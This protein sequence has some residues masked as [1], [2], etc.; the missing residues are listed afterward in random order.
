[1]TKASSRVDCLN[2]YA[3]W[4]TCI[5]SHPYIS[6]KLAKQL[7]LYSDQVMRFG[8]LEDDHLNPTDFSKECNKMYPIEVC[9]RVCVR[10]SIRS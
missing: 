1:M 7:S 2:Q 6:K 9:L 4:L 10:G 8:E 3:V 5:T